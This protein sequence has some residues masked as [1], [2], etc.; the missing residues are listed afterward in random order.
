MTVD[1]FSNRNALKNSGLNSIGGISER[2]NKILPRKVIT[3]YDPDRIEKLK[4]KL[5]ILLNGYTIQTDIEDYDI[6]KIINNARKGY[7]KNGK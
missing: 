3:D 7:E 6:E 1:Q 4:D 2:A 5:N